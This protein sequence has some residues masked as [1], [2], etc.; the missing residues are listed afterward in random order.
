MIEWKKTVVV[1]GA[2]DTVVKHYYPRL[3]P[4][5]KNRF[6]NLWVAD[7]LPRPYAVCHECQEKQMDKPSVP[8]HNLLYITTEGESQYKGEEFVC[9]VRN[10][11][12]VECDHIDKY[13]FRDK[14]IYDE[15]SADVVFVETP[16]SYHC[17]TV[18]K[19]LGRAGIII[20]DKPFSDKLEDIAYLRH[21]SASLERVWAFDHYWATGY[22][23][24]KHLTQL[25][26]D[27]GG[28][29]KI[30]FR[31]LEPNP[32]ESHRKGLPGMIAD[33]GSHLFAVLD[34]VGKLDTLK[35][36]D[37]YQGRHAGAW[38][39]DTNQLHKETFASISFSIESSRWDG[40]RKGVSYVG[41]GVGD[42][43]DK[44]LILIGP[45]GNAEIIFG[46]NNSP[47]IYLM[48]RI[49]FENSNEVMLL[50]WQVAVLPDG[51]SKM[52]KCVLENRD[53]KECL[54]TVDKAE[55]II[56]L[57]NCAQSIAGDKQS[58]L[59]IYQAGDSLENI[60][61]RLKGVSV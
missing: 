51:H 40:I 13:H 35:L 44:R 19:W 48:K 39:D 46:M 47:A 61:T 31:M 16:P 8:R 4:W 25:I 27:I 29:D 22:P 41:K 20:V 32:I 17:A 38:E 2:G 30:E 56:S 7:Y 43:E 45:N 55:C 50:P 53:L 24:R 5:V 6:I 42:K 23:L 21:N 3:M 18:E 60:V 10:R 36:E 34:L 15:Q 54:F 33:M 9:N 49:W 26:Y 58:K 37:V 11:K 1:V 28:V 14:K 59:P 52:I 57:V 12:S